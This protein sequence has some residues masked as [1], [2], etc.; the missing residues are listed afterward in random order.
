MKQGNVIVDDYRGTTRFPWNGVLWEA[1]GRG[2]YIHI[3]K[4]TEEENMTARSWR[5][6]VVRDDGGVILATPDGQQGEW[7]VGPRPLHVGEVW[8]ADSMSK[9]NAITKNGL[10][11]RHQ[12]R[13]IRLVDEIPDLRLYAS[14]ELRFLESSTPSILEKANATNIRPDLERALCDNAFVQ[15]E[16]E[17]RIY[18]V[19]Y[20]LRLDTVKF[21]FDRIV[22]N[23]DVRITL[24]DGIRAGSDFINV[25]K[26]YENIRIAFG[27]SE[28]ITVDGLSV[29]VADNTLHLRLPVT[30]EALTNVRT[31]VSVDV[32]KS[33]KRIVARRVGDLV[34]NGNRTT[35]H[36]MTLSTPVDIV[37]DERGIVTEGSIFDIPT[38]AF[39]IRSE[40]EGNASNGTGYLT[41]R[42]KSNHDIIIRVPV[43]DVIDGYALVL[44]PEAARLVQL[45]E[46]VRC[47]ER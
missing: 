33:K 13:L 34:L 22:L 28:V 42:M 35:V 12:L 2:K 24:R 20:F 27:H 8:I 18:D 10:V 3:K 19:V 6:S 46:G 38:D 41:I 4:I 1:S 44:E 47:A 16:H 36:T 11:E 45:P 31:A 17:G 9:T 30:R 5:V 21:D 39:D 14:E 26:A 43:V 7:A 29:I 15:V 40:Y 23:A 37:V 32:M 25:S